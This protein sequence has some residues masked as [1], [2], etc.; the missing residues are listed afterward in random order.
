MVTLT[1]W[2]DDPALD[3]VW[4]TADTD[5]LDNL[6]ALNNERFARLHDDRGPLVEVDHAAV[7]AWLDTAARDFDVTEEAA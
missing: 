3:E 5:Y 4:E 2:Y 7:S 1:R 6:T